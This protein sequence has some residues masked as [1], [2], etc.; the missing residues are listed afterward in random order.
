MF[1][2]GLYVYNNFLTTMNY[3]EG[4]NI[5]MHTGLRIYAMR[6]QAYSYACNCF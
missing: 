6:K 2:H 5:D 1:I 4:N 3:T